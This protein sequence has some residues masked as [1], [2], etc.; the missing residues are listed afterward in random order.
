MEEER[1]RRLESLF[2]ADLDA[3]GTGPV[4]VGSMADGAAG[5]AA[6]AEGEAAA[7]AGP[8][9]RKTLESVSAADAIIDAL[10]MAAHE[11]QQ[12]EEFE[13]EQRA[14]ARS[15][16]SS[17]GASS[18]RPPINPMMLGMGPSAFVLRAVSGVRANDLEQ[19]LLMLPFAGAQGDGVLGGGTWAGIHQGGDPQGMNNV[20]CRVHSALNLPATNCLPASW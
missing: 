15:G 1:E 4:A 5:G 13:A 7:A 11:E 9:G 16:G 2:E 6:G 18:S 20:S 19:A 12:R 3:S 10:D 8:S 17:G 14:R